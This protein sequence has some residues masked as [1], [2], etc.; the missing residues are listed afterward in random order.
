MNESKRLKMNHCCHLSEKAREKYNLMTTY[1]CGH[2]WHVYNQVS[3]QIMLHWSKLKVLNLP[4][5]FR[6]IRMKF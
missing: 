4:F 3:T 5:I 2:T 6:L 1:I